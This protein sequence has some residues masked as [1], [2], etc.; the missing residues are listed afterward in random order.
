[1]TP[2]T[3]HG[4]PAVLV[5]RAPERA[6]GLAARLRA[7]G[8]DAVV[9]PVIERSPATDLAALDDAARALAAGRYAWTVVTSVNA[10]DALT[11][12]AARSGADLVA[13]ATRWAAVGPATRRAL[14]AAGLA[15]DLL[16][17]DGDATAAGLVAA[18]PQAA[19]GDARRAGDGRVLLPLGDLASPTLSEG[20]TDR[21]WTPDVVTAY[22][23]VRHDLP[24][25]VAARARSGGFDLVV[26]SS[27]SVAR[28]IARQ[29]G[30]GTPAVAIGRPS[31]DAARAAGLTVA[32]VAAAPTDDGLAAAVVHALSDPRPTGANRV[33]DTSSKEHP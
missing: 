9:A 2:A 4:V 7:A 14:G 10:V 16:P 20:L 23:T 5:A 19:P 24:A 15:V 27:G 22:R 21:G 32:A 26:V 28:E 8:V 1:M 13:A 3:D 17:A 31:A 30:T 11:D 6:A 18:F 12:A 29:T 25:D 33:P